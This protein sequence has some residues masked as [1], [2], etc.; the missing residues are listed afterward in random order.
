MREAPRVEGK[1]EKPGGDIA[2]SINHTGVNI[3]W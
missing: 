2:P 1:P 3:F